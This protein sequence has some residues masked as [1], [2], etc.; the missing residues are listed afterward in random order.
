MLNALMCSFF[1][2]LLIRHIYDSLS[3]PTSSCSIYISPR[4]AGL[5]SE[6]TFV[7]RRRRALFTWRFS[8]RKKANSSLS[9]MTDKENSSVWGF[10]ISQLILENDFHFHFA[11]E[12]LFGGMRIENRRLDE[13]RN[14]STHTEHWRWSDRW[15][16]ARLCIMLQIDCDFMGQ[17]IT[18]GKRGEVDNF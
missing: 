10:L 11:Y 4:V 7:H 15:K 14:Q 2:L 12:I 3:D 18:G 17:S 8:S 16:V 5:F 1:F 13:L 6:W 9:L